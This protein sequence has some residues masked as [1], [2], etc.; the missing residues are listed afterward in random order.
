M[1]YPN[2]SVEK[3]Y[4]FQLKHFDW[5]KYFVYGQHPVKYV[6]KIPY[7]PIFLLTKEEVILFHEE[8]RNR[9]KNCTGGVESKV[10]HAIKMDTLK[11]F[12]V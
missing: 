3:P 12:K 8:H 7:R 5:K 10:K 9:E 6:L 2:T 1:K 11:T 4:N